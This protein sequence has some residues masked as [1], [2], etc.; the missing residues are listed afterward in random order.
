MK[1]TIHIHYNEYLDEAFK[2]Q[3]ISQY[4]QWVIPEKKDVKDKALL[5]EGVWKEK[6]DY[7]LEKLTEVTG[8]SFK[9]NYFP[10]YIV[11]GAVRT[12]SNPIVVKS[13]LTPKEF[14]ET[15]VHELIHCLFV[16][17]NEDTNL[18]NS[19]KLYK[20]N[21]TLLFAVLEAVLPGTM[22]GKNVDLTNFPENARY[23]DAVSEVKKEGYTTIIKNCFNK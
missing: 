13:R 12:F 10:I 23:A 3:G 4:P 9:R 16:D 1:P 20:N 7:I 15:M 14:I 17:N 22:E 6:E 19:P 2:A 8:L 21:H 18:L 5:F 11:S